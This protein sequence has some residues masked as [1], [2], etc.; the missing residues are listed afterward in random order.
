MAA[1]CPPEY[2]LSSK[3]FPE[4]LKS[5][6]EVL[7]APPYVINGTSRKG[8]YN[9]T[10]GKMLDP[11]KVA[12]AE[13]RAMSEVKLQFMEFG[14]RPPPFFDLLFQADIENPGAQPHWVLFPLYLDRSSGFGQL[15]ASAV[16]IFELPG[17]GLLRIARFLGDGSFQ[18][19]RLP[20]QAR[21]RI[22]EFPITL[23]GDRQRLRSRCR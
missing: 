9:P 16:E 11:T 20:P 19:M 4:K 7:D 15:L 2:D 1:S 13:E 18:A 10:S 3:I 5:Y 21:V 17:K 6:Q 8:G 12:G 14:L 23:I 22:H